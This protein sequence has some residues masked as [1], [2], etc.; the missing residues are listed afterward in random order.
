MRYNHISAT[1]YLAH[2]AQLRI[3]PFIIAVAAASLLIVSGNATWY[4]GA[5]AFFLVIA[6]AWVSHLHTRAI[7]QAEQELARIS[8]NEERLN[9]PGRVTEAVNGVTDLCSGVFGVW[10]R[11]IEAAR[12]HTDQSVTDLSARFSKLSTELA[13]TLIASGNTT[14]D[15]TD[16][17]DLPSIFR[18]CHEDLE[19]VVHSIELSRNTNSALVSEIEQLSGLTKSLKEMSDGIARIA[20]QTKLLALNASIEAA[21]AGD[22]GRGFSVVASEVRQLANVSATICQQIND[23]I[24]SITNSMSAARSISASFNVQEESAVEKSHRTIDEVLE[25]L[26]NITSHFSASAEILTTEG[27]HL[28]NEIADI[29]YSMQFQD[30][31]NQMLSQVV[32]SFSDVY[33]HLRTISM[34]ASVGKVPD[35]VV[36]DT[37]LKSLRKNY[38]MKE[39]HQNHDGKI[40]SM[41]SEGAVTFF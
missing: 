12:L 36:I 30:R 40:Q 41:P 23:N 38:T 18:K 32:S 17:E 26:R 37:V 10:A 6:G 31:V 1:H 24:S 15:L 27:N 29:L 14:Q 28:H 16:K 33:G 39:Q 5:G 7:E 35:R 11:Q 34:D 19:E 21:R 4:S 22:A 13:S 2:S 3:A 8:A 25:R 9:A 20:D